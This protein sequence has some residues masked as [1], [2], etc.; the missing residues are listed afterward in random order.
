MTEF[1][2]FDASYRRYFSQLLG[3]SQGPITIQQVSAILGTP[4]SRTKYI[5][6][7][8]AKSGWLFRVKQGLYVPI[9]PTIEGEQPFAEDPWIIANALFAP[10][11]M[12]GW[13]AISHWDLTDQIF[14]HTFVYTQTPQ[15]KSKQEYLNHTFIVHKV[16]KEH[17]FGLKTIWNKT[18]KLMISDPSRT[19][20]DFLDM[21]HLFG[22]SA[23]LYEAFSEYLKSEH[24]D[25]DLLVEYAL[26][27]KNKAILKRLGFLLEN[28]GLIMPEVYHKLLKN[29]SSGK[30]K[31]VPTLDCPRLITKWQ[32]WI[33]EGW[34]ENKK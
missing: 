22:G 27:M 10:C 26:R 28:E 17:F 6:A 19:I 16:S 14:N 31:L 33:P 34:K 29:M 32:L 24:K 8:L 12:G 5:L 15:K 2:G 18:I 25:M 20:I 13:D 11:Y 9:P 7:R 30:V 23:T 21:P 3:R 4:H 1:K